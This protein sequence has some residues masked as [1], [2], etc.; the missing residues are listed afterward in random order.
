MPMIQAE[1]ERL[2]VVPIG[3]PCNRR[4]TAGNGGRGI[5]QFF[6]SLG[7]RHHFEEWRCIRLAG[8]WGGRFG[9]IS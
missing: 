6:G 5:S 2:G 8:V 9:V 4:R 7:D 3:A 1:S